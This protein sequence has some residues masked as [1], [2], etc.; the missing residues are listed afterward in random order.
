MPLVFH[1][2]KNEGKRPFKEL[3]LHCQ[4][5]TASKRGVLRGQMNNTDTHTRGCVL[6]R[7]TY[8]I[9]LCGDTPAPHL[10]FEVQTHCETW[11]MAVNCL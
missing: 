6:K 3:L 2:V 1:I 5:E 4:V 8:E 7:L 9:Q 10:S 11:E